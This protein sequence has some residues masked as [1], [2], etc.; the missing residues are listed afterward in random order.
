MVEEFDTFKVTVLG[1]TKH[2]EKKKKGHQYIMLSTRFFDDHKVASLTP[3]QKLA[4]IYLLLRCGDDT[5]STVVAT[6]KQMRSACGATTLR[7]GSTLKALQSFQLVKIEEFQSLK[8]LHHKTR[9]HITSQDKKG[10]DE[11]PAQRSLDLPPSEPTD[12][13]SDRIL[14]IWNDN[15]GT[16]P[17]AK[18]LNPSRKKLTAAKWKEHPTAEYWVD[19]VKRLA[20][21]NFCS[22]KNDRGWVATFDWFLK[23]DNHLKVIEGKY[24]NRTTAAST[25]QTR[26]YDKLDEL[27]K[28]W[29]TPKAD[30]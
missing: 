15:C 22:G 3:Q 29:S 10:R 5:Q 24:D 11:P 9:H 6:A 30:A 20:A 18:G 1:W 8:T 16:L 2:N 12:K 17:K 28:Q 13:I 7:V 27:E 14:N 21:S 4:Y 25:A 19:V 23:G 26:K